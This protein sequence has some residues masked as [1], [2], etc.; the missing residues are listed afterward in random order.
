MKKIKRNIEIL[1]D[2]AKK[3]SAHL[4]AIDE[5]Y[6]GSVDAETAKTIKKKIEDS[7]NLINK[8][9]Q[10]EEVHSLLDTAFKPFTSLTKELKQREKK[11]T[12]FAEGFLGMLATFGEILPQMTQL[13][14]QLADEKTAESIS[15]V[16]DQFSK[17]EKTVGATAPKMQACK[18]IQTDDLEKFTVLSHQAECSMKGIHLLGRLM[19][20]FECFWKINDLLLQEPEDADLLFNDSSS[21]FDNEPIAPEPKPKTK[22]AIKKDKEDAKEELPLPSSPPLNL[23]PSKDEGT[24]RMEAQMKGYTGDQC[25]E[26]HNFTMVRNGTCL[27]CDTCGSTTV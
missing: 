13:S 22:K 24:L 2:A 20:R 25:T 4:K 10:K 18:L 12:D 14:Y 26:C 16:R 21:D 9:Q 23:P 3:L 5:C 11:E 19:D 17:L 6:A 15:K 27:K 7:L 8:E 1:K